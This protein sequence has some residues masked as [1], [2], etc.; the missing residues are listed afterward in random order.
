MA[1][2]KKP[3]AVAGKKKEKKNVTNGIAYILATFNNTRITITDMQGNVIAWSTAGANSFNGAK[4]S[5]P[6]A[7]QIT[8]ENAGRKAMENGIRYLDVKMEGPG[9]GR[10]AAVR[11]LQSLGITINGIADVTK[12]PHN[13]CRAKK[14]RRV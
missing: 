2:N 9:S 10:E 4:K 8:A 13:G 14:P 3:A 11:T 12:I 5:T 7:A 6:Y 1:D